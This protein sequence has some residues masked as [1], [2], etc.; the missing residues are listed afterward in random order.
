VLAL[1]KYVFT[2]IIQTATNVMNTLLKTKCHCRV[3]QGVNWKAVYLEA[4]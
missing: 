1:Q 4:H 3:N 2:N